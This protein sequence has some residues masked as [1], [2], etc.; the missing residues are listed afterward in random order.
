MLTLYMD[1]I[2]PREVCELKRKR[3]VGISFFG[4]YVSFEIEIRLLIKAPVS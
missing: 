4:A 1:V 3:E 2:T